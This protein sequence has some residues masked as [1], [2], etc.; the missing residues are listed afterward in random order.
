MRTQDPANI[1]ADFDKSLTDVENAFTASEASLPD[2]RTK[3]L[4]AEYLFV[5]AATLFEGFVSDLFV[6]YINRNSEKFRAYLIGKINI[7]TKDEYAKRSMDYIEKT[8]PHPT[9][10][11]IREILDPSGYNVT[12]KTT[13]EMKESAGKWL[14]N[15]DKTKFTS[16]STQQCAIIDL[17][18]AV[19][20]FLAHRSQSADDTMQTALIATNLPAALRRGNKK[21]AEVGVYLRA[22]K[23]NQCRLSHFLVELQGLA[24]KFCP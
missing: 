5:A 1:R 7:D 2:D 18:K 22:T 24:V 21:V 19:R 6:A 16:V 15:I 9:V 4:I 14:A 17:V 10:E 12:F 13:D 8:M 20:N 23:N 11:R 3:K